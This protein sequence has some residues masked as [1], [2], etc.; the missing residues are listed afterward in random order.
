M[1]LFLIRGLMAIAWSAVVV[2]V[3]D[4]LTTPRD[5]RRRDPGRDLPADRRGRLA[6]RRAQPTRLCMS[7]TAV[8]RRP[9][10]REAAAPLVV[11]R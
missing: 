5:G 2:A 6:D 4:S 7:S 9:G 11:R 3:A 1:Q 10:P 8:T